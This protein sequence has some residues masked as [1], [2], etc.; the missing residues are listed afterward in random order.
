MKLKSLYIS[1]LNKT[2]LFKEKRKI[3]KEKIYLTFRIDNS[4]IRNIFK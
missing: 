1:I 3:F 4:I 2:N